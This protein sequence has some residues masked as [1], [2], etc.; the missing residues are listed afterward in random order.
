MTAR[1]LLDQTQFNLTKIE[2][3]G[4][5]FTVLRPGVPKNGWYYYP[6]DP[7]ANIDGYPCE[8]LTPSSGDATYGCTST[9]L[10]PPPQTFEFKNN[11]Y[12]AQFNNAINLRRIQQTGSLDSNTGGVFEID[13]RRND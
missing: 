13:R 9:S 5:E 8:T 2:I 10:Y 12:N 6:I 11:D 3:N 4:N 1:I 7:A